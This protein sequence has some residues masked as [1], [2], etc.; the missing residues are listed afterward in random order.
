MLVTTCINKDWEE[1]NDNLKCEGYNV[2]SLI[3]EDSTLLMLKVAYKIVFGDLSFHIKNYKCPTNL[4]F[5]AN[6][7]FCDK[8]WSKQNTIKIFHHEFHLISNIKMYA[9][10]MGFLHMIIWNKVQI[11]IHWSNG[12]FWIKM[13]ME[14]NLN[15]DSI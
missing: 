9:F 3:I 13:E 2:W 7:V 14:V 1:N 15:V 12:S 6:F 5:L 10:G 4:D 8:M 11:Q